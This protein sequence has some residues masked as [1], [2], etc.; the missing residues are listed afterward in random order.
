M[1]VEDMSD[2]SSRLWT[3][4]FASAFHRL[5]GKRPVKLKYE[6]SLVRFPCD[7]FITLSVKC[8]STLNKEKKKNLHVKEDLSPDDR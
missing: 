5:G 6:M 4:V 1:K 7:T 3:K 2:H 8:L